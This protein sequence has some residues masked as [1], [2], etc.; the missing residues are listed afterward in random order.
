MLPT[1]FLKRYFPS[2]PDWLLGGLFLVAVLWVIVLLLEISQILTRQDFIRS[3]GWIVRPLYIEGLRTAMS[4]IPSSI[5][6]SITKEIAYVFL[7]LLIV[8]PVYFV[9]GTLLETR[10]TL[11]T[12]L[13][14]SFLV[15]KILF[16]CYMTLTILFWF[17]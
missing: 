11:A 14:V 17:G 1:R 9:I 8:S 13:G 6:S 4:L 3:W 16:G 2:A 12:V 10:R 5:D 7:G 15:L